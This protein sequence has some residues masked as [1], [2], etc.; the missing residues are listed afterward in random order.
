M[1]FSVYMA[2]SLDGFIATEDGG[3]DWL[4]QTGDQ[5]VDMSEFGDL[6]FGEFIVTVDAMIMGRHTMDVIAN[7]NLTPEQWPYGDVPIYVMS[8]TLSELPKH[9][10][11]SV[12]LRSSLDEL[13]KEL[14]ELQVQHVYVD[15]GKIINTCLDKKLIT[16]LQ[17]TQL[18]IILGKGIRLFSERTQPINLT[19]L[20]TK[21]YPNNFLT[22][23]YQVQY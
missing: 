4:Q 19:K 23:S 5:S 11:D 9:M 20:S 18:P 7:M 8:T 13:I 21:T 16:S 2:M 14:T 3:V 15:G 1:K 12:K 22:V 10:P 6:G 17:L